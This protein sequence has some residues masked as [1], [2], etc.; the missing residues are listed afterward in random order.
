M[1]AFEWACGSAGKIER[2]L[3]NPVPYK[4]GVGGRN[5]VNE[6]GGNETP[7]YIPFYIM[8]LNL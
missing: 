7:Q 8:F 3:I 1:H 5:G 6:D 2:R 4:G